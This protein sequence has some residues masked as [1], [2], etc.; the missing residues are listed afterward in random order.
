MDSNPTNPANPSAD[1]TGDNPYIFGDLLADEARLANQTTLFSNYL[2]AHAHGWVPPPLRQIL[3]LGCGNGQLSR[4]LIHLYPTARLL[5]IDRDPQVIARAQAATAPR[6][7]A[8]LTFQVGDAEQDL[9]PGPFDLIY[10]GLLLLHVRQPAR[11]IEN[12]YTA[13]APGGYLWIKEGHPSIMTAIDDPAYRRLFELLVA[14]MTAIGAHPLVFN[15][16]PAFLQAAGFE[17]PRI[18]LEQYPLGGATLEGRATLGIL[19]GAI[20][21]ARGAISRLQQISEREIIDLYSRVS[22]RA[23]S[24]TEPIGTL[25]NA[26]VIARRPL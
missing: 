12:A 6:D 21:N 22:A 11:V 16:L 25:T 15:D 3:D 8:A 19:L 7:Q 20:Y 26:N 4:T 9:P 18:E 10:A 23:R 13:L 2:R 1:L 5:G 24:A 14:T 17:A